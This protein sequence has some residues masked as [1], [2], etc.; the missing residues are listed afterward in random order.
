MFSLGIG[1]VKLSVLF[2]YRQLFVVQTKSYKDAPNLITMA[3]IV[4]V[5]VWTTVYTLSQLSRCSLGQCLPLKADYW[6]YP[7]GITHFITDM[8]IY[9]LPISLVGSL[10]NAGDNELLTHMHLGVEVASFTVKTDRCHVHFSDRS[11]A[12]ATPLL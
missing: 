7:F 5:A 10:V 3:M 6:G 2:L 8:L 11:F 9:I 1:L 4:L 12:S